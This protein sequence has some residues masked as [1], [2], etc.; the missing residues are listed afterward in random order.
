LQVLLGN[1]T[2]PNLSGLL[3]HSDI[4]VADDAYFTANPVHDA[5]F[6]NENLNRIRRAK[7]LVRTA[8]RARAS[9]I[10]ANPTDVEAWETATGTDGNYLVGPS[11]VL[12]SVGTLWG[13]PLYE[14][15][16]LAVGEALVGDGSKAVVIDRHDAQIYTTRSHEDFFV[17]NIIVLLAEMRAAFAVTRPAAFVHVEL[18]S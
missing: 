4:T 6:D 9:F 18:A 16:N 11:R 1:G 10:I 8:G 17:R 3:D 2:A 13:L 12:G 5:G 7:S 15:S 14:D